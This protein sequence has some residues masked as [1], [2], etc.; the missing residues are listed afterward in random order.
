M[1]NKQAIKVLNGM[2][3]MA[4]NR[5]SEDVQSASILAINALIMVDDLK[6]KNAMLKKALNVSL[7]SQKNGLSY[8]DVKQTVDCFLNHEHRNKEGNGSCKN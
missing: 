1:T 3:Y 5:K 6:A 4:L 7:E 2:E 8:E